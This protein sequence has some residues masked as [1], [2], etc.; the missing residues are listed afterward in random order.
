MLSSTFDLFSHN[1][2]HSI[3]FTRHLFNVIDGFIELNEADVMT[4]WYITISYNSSVHSKG[5]LNKLL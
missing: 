3:H 5:Q 1:N 4:C 2:K